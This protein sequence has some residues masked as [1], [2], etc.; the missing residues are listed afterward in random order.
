M[1]APEGPEG[2]P[3]GAKMDPLEA[4]EG[5]RERHKGRG[6]FNTVLGPILGPKMDPK[7]T[8]N[9]AKMGPESEPNLS[10]LLATLFDVDDYKFFN[11]FF[12]L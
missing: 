3:G 4:Q 9:G 8:Q 6:E 11:N 12:L 1:W 10:F 7:G 5:S 2:T